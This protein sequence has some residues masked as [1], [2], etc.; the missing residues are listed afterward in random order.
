MRRRSKEK[1]KSETG[2]LV[3]NMLLQVEQ[4]KTIWQNDQA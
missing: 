3:K 1:F 2:K 4:N